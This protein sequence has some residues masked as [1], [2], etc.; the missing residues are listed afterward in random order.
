MNFANLVESVLLERAIY[1]PSCGG[2][3]TH[4]KGLTPSLRC[5][6]CEMPITK[7]E[8]SWAHQEEMKRKTDKI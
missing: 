4:H 1:C 7:Y 6:K 8:N 2:K 5:N 3:R